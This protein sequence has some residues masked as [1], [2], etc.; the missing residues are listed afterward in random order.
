[1]HVAFPYRFFWMKC[2]RFDLSGGLTAGEG[3]VDLDSV[4][5][6]CD[7]GGYYSKEIVDDLSDLRNVRCS[8][9]SAHC[10]SKQRIGEIRL[11]LQV[12]LLYY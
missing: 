12:L 6:Y 8:L 11:F 1:M 10:D 9:L 5:F 3:G 7:Y 4:G 2:A